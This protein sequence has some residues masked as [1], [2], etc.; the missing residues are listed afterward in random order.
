MT[1]AR[2]IHDGDAIDHI[3]SANVSAG[4]VVV[5]G[6]LVSIAKL[7]IPASH[8]GALH[9]VG[10][11]DVVKSTG[12][13]NAGAAVYWQANGNP[14]GGEAGSGA[15]TATAG[16]NKFMG[17]AVKAAGNN[18]PTVR[19]ALFG[20]PAITA[21]HYGP[22]NNAIADPGDAEAIPLTASGTVAIVTTEAGGET[23]SLAAPSF[24]GQELLLYMK[25]DGGDAVITCAT[26]V[27]QTGNNTITMNDA[28]DT[29]RLVAIEVG[30]NKR[31]RVVVNDGCTLATV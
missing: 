13:I 7:D 27:N 30:S 19:L 14:V 26:G 8:L 11:Y 12:E 20:S 21:N 9:R 15:A 25:T 18:D 3:P 28:G 31:W 6:D 4:D 29:L 5:Q 17:W 10:I 16:G 23:R 24:V 22:L 1:Q 2:F